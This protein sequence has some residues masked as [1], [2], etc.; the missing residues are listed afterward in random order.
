M[1]LPRRRP[2]APRRAPSG[3][4]L[5]ELIMVIALVGALAVFALPRL[6]DLTA[7]RLGAYADELRAQTLAM[8][9][10]A[11]T[12][13]RPVVATLT[14]SG[15]DFAYSGGAAIASLPCPATATPCIAEGG[16]RTA[17]FNHAN[18]GMVVTSS[19]SALPITVSYGGTSIAFVLEND[20]GLMRNG[21]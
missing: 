14:G 9:R 10:L 15:V 1:S 7:W 2:P 8:Q 18:G 19:G 12:Q 21:P 6:L 11:L 20:T 3:F 5:V 17:T 4:T 13:R 16:T